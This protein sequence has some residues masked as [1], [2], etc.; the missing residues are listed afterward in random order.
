MIYDG[1]NNIHEKFFWKKNTQREREREREIEGEEKG[2]R[3]E[4]E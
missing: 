2:M 3:E 1:K 4:R